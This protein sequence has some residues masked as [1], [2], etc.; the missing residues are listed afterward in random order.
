MLRKCWNSLRTVPF[1]ARRYIDGERTVHLS[2]K[3]LCLEIESDLKSLLLF[4]ELAKIH[5]AIVGSLILKTIL[6]NST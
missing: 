3:R 2:G 5:T 1:S 4:Q 6:M